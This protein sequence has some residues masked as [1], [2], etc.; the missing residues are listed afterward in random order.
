LGLV[1]RYCIRVRIRG[2]GAWNR[3]DL[4]CPKLGSR[5][6]GLGFWVWVARTRLVVR[7]LH[8]P[9]EANVDFPLI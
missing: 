6:A 2:D 1:F 4:A 9:R 3:A 8:G 5:V 7:T